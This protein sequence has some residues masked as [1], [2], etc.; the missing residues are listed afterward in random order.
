MKAGQLNQKIVIEQPAVVSDGEGGETTT[1]STYST[2][3]AS[4]RPLR[5]REYYEANQTRADVTAEIR[6]RY[7]A[8]ITPK[9]RVKYV[10]DSVTRYYDIHAVQDMWE[11]DREIV[12]MVSERAPYSG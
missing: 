7:I 4:I 12:M 5:G 6:I 1:W 2:V 11:R 9:M 8:G 3:W 10:L